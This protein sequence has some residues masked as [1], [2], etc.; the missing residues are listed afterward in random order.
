MPY[1]RFVRQLDGCVLCG[2]RSM[3]GLNCT[4][5]T[6]AMW[7]YRAS[8]G[9]I[10]TTGCHVRDLTDDCSGGTNLRQMQTV[11]LKYGI[12]TGKLYQPTNFDQVVSWVSTGRY[13]S[14]LNIS[15]APFVGTPYDRFHGGFRGNHD[16]YLSNRGHTAG[17]LRVGDPGATGFADIPISLLRNAAGKLDLGGGVTVNA[18]YGG[19][20]AYAYVAPADPAVPETLYHFAIKTKTPVYHAPETSPYRTLN[21]GSG[22]CRK[23]KVDGHIWYQIVKPGSIVNGQWLHAG[24]TF[25]VTPI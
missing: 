3:G 8:Q 5:A 23:T 2:G 15:Y 12:D 24:P 7:L 18:E 11:S 16:L 6:E 22:S 9:A 19:G 1:E 21:S 20:K 4:C 14:H 17:T 13:G 10:S 25:T